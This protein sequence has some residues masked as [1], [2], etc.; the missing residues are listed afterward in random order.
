[1]CKCTAL[2][3]NLALRL[4]VH[5]APASALAKPTLQREQTGTWYQAVSKVMQSIEM[6]AQMM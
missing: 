5:H 4:P 3:A 1:M 2:S 6:T